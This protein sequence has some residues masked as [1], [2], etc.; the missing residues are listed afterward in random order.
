MCIL[1]SDEEL[2]AKGTY[3]E[4]TFTVCVARLRIY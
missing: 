1:V 4:K 3:R 2:V